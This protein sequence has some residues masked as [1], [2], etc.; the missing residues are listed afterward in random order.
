MSSERGSGPT[1]ITWKVKTMG[2]GPTFADRQELALTVN[3][4]PLAEPKDFT[5]DGYRVMWVRAETPAAAD[6]LIKAAE[7]AGFEWVHGDGTMRLVFRA[8]NDRGPGKVS[9]GGNRL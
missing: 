5:R 9:M 7:D 6:E 2:E 1:W 4:H 3:N 8:P